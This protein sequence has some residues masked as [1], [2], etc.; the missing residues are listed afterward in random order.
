[1]RE[2]DGDGER[3]DGV[4]LSVCL[5]VFLSLHFCLSVCLSPS[6][7]PSLSPSLPPS[8]YLS[9]TGRADQRDVLAHSGAGPEVEG[10]DLRE[11][12]REGERE[13]EREREREERE[14]HSGDWQE[15]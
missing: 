12:E 10:P 15:A 5:S 7:P 4:C 14:C 11:G 13:S 3:D 8:I 1:V 6:L 9:L 2:R